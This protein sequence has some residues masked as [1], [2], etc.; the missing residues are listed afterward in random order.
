MIT[1]LATKAFAVFVALHGIVHGIGFAVPWKLMDMPGVDYTT[2][3]LWGNVDLGD[4]G[5]RLFGILWLAAIAAFVVAAYGIW[6]R[7]S[8]ATPAL[9]VATVGSLVICVLASPSAIR[10]TA[11]DVAILVGVA[12]LAIVARRGR[13][14]VPAT[15]QAVSS[16]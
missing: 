10:G 7:R 12:A 2:T 9:A 14:A 1:G 4:T 15:H 6:R 13:G 16:K 8:W 11:I 3:V 5:M